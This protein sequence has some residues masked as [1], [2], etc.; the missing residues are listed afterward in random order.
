MKTAADTAQALIDD[1]KRQGLAYIEQNCQP[2]PTVSRDLQA[3]L[4]RTALQLNNEIGRLQGHVR[5]LCLQ[6]QLA[7]ELGYSL[8]ARL[9]KAY[10]DLADAGL[11]ETERDD[12][13]RDAL[14]FVVNT[15]AADELRAA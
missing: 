10:E 14:V 13:A 1:A 11:M 7:D 3:E 15:G 12:S 6:L 4:D 5:T 8:R 9:A 2:L